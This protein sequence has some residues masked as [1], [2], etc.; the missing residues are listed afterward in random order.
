MLSNVFKIFQWQQQ[1]GFDS[2]GA[3][4]AISMRQKWQKNKN[5]K[6][7]IF[8][9]LKKYNHCIVYEL[10]PLSSK[11]SE[12]RAKGQQ[13]GVQLHGTIKFDVESGN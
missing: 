10:R 4:E 7:N 3:C 1:T 9:L 13:F 12:K 8:N 5:K 6:L 11:Q 2:C